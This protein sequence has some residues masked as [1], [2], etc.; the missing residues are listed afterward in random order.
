M[1]KIKSLIPRRGVNSF[2]SEV[3]ISKIILPNI[4]TTQNPLSDITFNLSEN[5]LG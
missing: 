4:S 1:Y 5:G 3:F 2:F